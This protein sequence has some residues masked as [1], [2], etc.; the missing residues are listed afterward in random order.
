MAKKLTRKQ[1]IKKGVAALR[2]G[3]FRRG[4]SALAT[5]ARGKH[6]NYCCLGVLCEL[7]AK[8]GVVEKKG[9]LYGSKDHAY[10]G[11]EEQMYY[12]PKEVKDWA[13]LRSTQGTRG[14]KLSLAQLNDNGESFKKIADV[15]ESDVDSLFFKEN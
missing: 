14:S 15:I 2:S 12:L 1:I 13:G 4:E 6:V 10:Y 7:A 3:K 5:N 8:E 9:Y 11:A